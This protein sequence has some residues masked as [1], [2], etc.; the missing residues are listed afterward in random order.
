MFRAF[1]YFSCTAKLEATANL[2]LESGLRTTKT[3]YWGK[4]ENRPSSTIFRTRLTPFAN[5]L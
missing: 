1:E 2:M 3:F 4:V 5:A